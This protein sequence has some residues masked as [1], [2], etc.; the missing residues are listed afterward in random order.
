LAQFLERIQTLVVVMWMAG[1]IIK[2]TVFFHSAAVAAASTLGLKNYQV[3]VLPIAVAVVAISKVF[4]G[5]H[6]QLTDF[7]FK[8]WPYYGFAVELLIPA[9]ILLI[10]IIRKKGGKNKP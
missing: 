10:A 6:L 8:I 5:T 2:A 4:Y 3:T 7:L 1:V 9:V